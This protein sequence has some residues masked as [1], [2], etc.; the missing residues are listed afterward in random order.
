MG[1]TPHPLTVPGR[2]GRPRLPGKQKALPLSYHLV[3]L[4]TRK[5]RDQPIKGDELAISVRALAA[6]CDEKIEWLKEGNIVMPQICDEER[7]WEKL[8]DYV[9]PYLSDRY[10]VVS[11]KEGTIT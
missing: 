11:G 5:Y 10:I 1:V 3:T 4:P 2:H 8:R 9:A 7:S 6:L